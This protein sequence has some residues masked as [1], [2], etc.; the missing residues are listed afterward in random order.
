MDNSSEIMA[1]EEMRADQFHHKKWSKPVFGVMLIAVSAAMVVL[2]T[3]MPRPVYHFVLLLSIACIFGLVFNGRFALMLTRRRF[4]NK[5][6]HYRLS[7]LSEPED[8]SLTAKDA[9]AKVH[10]R[11]QKELQKRGLR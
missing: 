2:P 6:P 11:Q 1:L 9:L 3:I 5:R 8:L 4:K 10:E 7:Q